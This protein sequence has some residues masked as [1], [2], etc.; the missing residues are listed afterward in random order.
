MHVFSQVQLG[1]NQ[2][3]GNTGAE[4]MDLRKPLVGEA[5]E[6][7]GANHAVAEE[8][9]IGVL[10]AERTEALQLILQREKCVLK[11]FVGEY[12]QLQI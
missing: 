11:G 4:L 6:R 9:D 2:D 10:V 1:T 8:E 7:A 12:L 3:Q 5:V